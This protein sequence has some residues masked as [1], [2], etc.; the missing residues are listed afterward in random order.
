MIDYRK[1]YIYIFCY[2]RKIH[3]DR[4]TYLLKCPTQPHMCENLFPNRE[5]GFGGK[6]WLGGETQLAEVG[7]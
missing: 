4:N 2:A 3:V 1:K 6:Q 7:H 5:A